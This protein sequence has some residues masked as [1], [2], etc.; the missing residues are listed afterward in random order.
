MKKFLGFS[1]VAVAFAL[2]VSFASAATYSI[3]QP[4]TMGS[5]G[6]EVTELQQ[7]LVAK[8]YLVMPAGVSY[9]YFGT[10]T[11]NALAAFQAANGISPAVG[12]Y[13]PVTAAKVNSMEM[14]SNSNS[15]NNNSGSGLSGGEASLESFDF[16]AGDDSDVEEGASA[17]IA[18]IEFDVEDGDVQV[19]RI[20]L[21]LV[22][23]SGNDEEDP[24]DTFESLRLLVDGKEIAEVDLSDEDE[25]LDEDE[26]TVRLSNLDFIVDEGDTANIVVEITA[27]NS[28]DGADTDDANWT[29]NVEEDGIRATDAEGIEQY[30]GDDSEEVDFSV[31]VEGD[32]EELN[33]STSSDDP[34]SETLKVEDDAK[35]DQYTI[36]AFDLEAEESDIELDQITLVATTSGTTSNM[37]SDLVL[38]IDGEEFDDWSY[39]TSSATTTRSIVFDI[40]GDFTIDADSEVTVALKAEFKAANGTNYSSGA[41]IAVGI[42]G[43]AVEGEGA[44]DVDSTGS[45]SGDTHT[46][47][48]EGIMVD[49]DTKS[50]D[51]TGTDDT[52]GEFTFVVDVTAFE[53]DA[54]VELAATRGTTESN[55]GFN[56]VILDGNNNVVTLGTTTFSIEADEDETSNDRVEISQ[57]DTVQFTVTAFYTANTAGSYK[58]RLYSVNH[59]STDA[60]AD[61]QFLLVPES[62]YRTSATYIEI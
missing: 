42:A 13:G 44:D 11:K 29:I 59:K 45:A 55:T 37:I 57:N 51:S 30:I 5:T 61:T 15:G 23:D 25:Y 22:A 53:E 43:G 2:T 33:V 31:E 49:L 32:G 8:G 10:L 54:F 9:G 16:S 48:T 52:V 36:F 24:W 35:S 46:L 18:E 56:V 34:E 27:Q 50:A 7:M 6:S 17:E 41:T 21:A 40:D 1:V 3:T 39:V 58:A 28:V 38:E 14:G 19:N 12:Y 47:A 26:G 20:D 62:T 4:L 60:D